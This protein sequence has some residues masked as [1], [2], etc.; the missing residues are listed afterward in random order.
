MASRP[1][2]VLPRRAPRHGVPPP[3]TRGFTAASK[4]RPHVP[5]RCSRRWDGRLQL[6]ALR[7]PPC[8][9]VNRVLA[10]IAATSEFVSLPA[11]C[12]FSRH[13]VPPSGLIQRTASFLQRGSNSRSLPGPCSRFAFRRGGHLLGLGGQSPLQ[14]AVTSPIA[15][16]GG[17]WTWGSGGQ[18]VWRARDG[19]LL[20]VQ[21]RWWLVGAGSHILGEGQGLVCSQEDGDAKFPGSR[22]GSEL[23]GAQCE[24]E[25]LPVQRDILLHD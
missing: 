3:S 7:W 11:S 17:R 23:R 9:L 4:S 15:F 16:C 10:T 25:S 18:E 20:S 8:S 14:E 24:A 19:H 13:F 1:P 5:P 22:G 12:L 21:L 6:S 2:A